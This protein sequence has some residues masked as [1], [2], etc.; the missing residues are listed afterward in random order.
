M[1]EHRDV[2]IDSDPNVDGAP[3]YLES[4]LSDDAGENHAERLAMVKEARHKAV[5]S[6]YKNRF[7]SH[8]YAII[9]VGSIV[10]SLPAVIGEEEAMMPHFHFN[11][12]FHWGVRGIIPVR[13]SA[14]SSSN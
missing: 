12:P 8:L 6:K 13:Y 11:L 4:L 9:E 1:K 5:A 3:S 2:A 14:S 7:A 10:F